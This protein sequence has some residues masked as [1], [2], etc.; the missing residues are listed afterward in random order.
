MIVENPGRLSV[1]LMNINKLP[2][3]RMASS[4]ECEASKEL[5]QKLLGPALKQFA[6]SL[7]IRRSRAA[8]Y[9]RI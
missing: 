5:D 4:Y 3:L 6:I 9:D 8:N 2:C 1:S 7:R